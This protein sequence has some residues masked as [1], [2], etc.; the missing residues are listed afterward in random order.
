M[1]KTLVVVE[2]P[3]K[4]KTIEKYLGGDFA[5]RASVGH[6]RDLSRDYDGLGVDVSNDFAPHFVVTEDSEKNVAALRKAFRGSDGVVLATDFDREGE[7]IAYDVAEVLGVRPD[8]AQRV[9]FTEITRD[10]ILEAFQRPR[11]IDMQLVDA[12]RA[13]RILDK[14]VGFGISPILW[15]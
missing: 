6:I 13:R 5:V 11:Q 15:R 1:A 10:A 8:E 7:A 12:Q 4:A 2:S 9:T 3:A 14:L